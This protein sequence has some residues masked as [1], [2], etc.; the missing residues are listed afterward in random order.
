MAV[1][2]A[3]SLMQAVEEAGLNGKAFELYERRRRAKVDW[4]VS[5][6]WNIG[7]ICHLKNPVLR[8]LRNVLLPKLLRGE[9]EKQMKRLYTIG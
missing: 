9:G 7:K 8:G 3:Y 2:D 6:S 4:T 1:E 5:N